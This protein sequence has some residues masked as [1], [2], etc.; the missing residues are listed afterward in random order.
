MKSVYDVAEHE[1]GQRLDRFLRSRLPEHSRASVVELVERG[2][3]R[4][5]GRH[6]HKG[7]AL[8]SGDRVELQAD[9]QREGLAAAADVA[10]RVLYEDDWLLAVDKPAGV[11]S[12]SLRPGETGTMA[13][14]LVARYP[15]LLGV[16]YRRLEPGLLHRLDNDTSGVL[17][18][19]RTQES[20]AALRELHERGGID[21]HYLALCAGEVSAP[22][23]LQ[24]FLDASQRR[25]RVAADALAGG[26]PIGTELV[27]SQRHGNLSLV[28]V[29]VAFAA[30]HQV[31]AQL[32]ALGHPIAGDTLYG[33]PALPGL[34]H[35]FLHASS[36]TLAHPLTKQRLV[37]EA[38]LPDDLSALLTRIG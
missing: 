16:G 18:A 8:R 33:G 14:A 30:R 7:T 22:Q 3:V 38:A 17:L 28:D 12:H 36:V 9:A 20:F 32:A 31:R 29:R 23:L 37:I 1:A 15:E 34:T 10:L 13:S 35:H 19:A 24:A 11:P 27:S 21:K 25:V 2:A 6:A 4:V 5:N 26:K